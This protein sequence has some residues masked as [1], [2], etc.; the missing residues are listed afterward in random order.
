VAT[1]ASSLAEAARRLDQVGIEEARLEARVLL[2]HLLGRSRAWVYRNPDVPLPPPQIE[3]FRQ[4][5]DARLRGEPLAYLVGRREFYGRDF[6]VDRRVLI[7]RPETEALLE[8]ALAFARRLPTPVPHVVDVGTGSGILA[9]SLALELPSA[10]VVAVDRSRDALIVARENAKRHGVAD[11]IAFVEGDLL[12]GLAGPFDVIAANLPYVP[13]GEIDA[14]PAEL[15]REPRLALDGGP[16]GLDLYPRFL[17]GAADILGPRGALFAEVGSNQGPAV[18]S[19][20]RSAFPNRPVQVYPDLEGRDRV[21]AVL[22]AA[23]DVEAVGPI[24]SAKLYG[25]REFAGRFGDGAEQ[26]ADRV[27]RHRGAAPTGAAPARE[28]SKPRG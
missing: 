19:L 1:V 10:A 17:R 3:A 28:E 6:V 23:R 8:V 20:A 15:R 18:V 7:P 9:V 13:T 22:P 24:E 5:V 27:S 14:A 4:L 21:V 16:R 25:S 12:D 2:E 11:R 26:T